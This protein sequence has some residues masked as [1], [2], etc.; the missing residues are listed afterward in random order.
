[1]ATA[2]IRDTNCRCRR[3]DLRRAIVREWLDVKPSI[4]QCRQS[5]IVQMA[6]SPNG[7]IS[8]PAMSCVNPKTCI[9]KTLDAVTQSA[10]K[11]VLPS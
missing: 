8:L 5:S 2:L 6:I 11:I 4:S 10:L 1:M 7:S 3:P 9:L